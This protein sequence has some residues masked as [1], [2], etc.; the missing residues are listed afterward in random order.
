M[1]NKPNP[2]PMTTKW[3]KSI[4]KRLNQLETTLPATPATKTNNRSNS[5]SNHS[6][7]DDTFWALNELK[8]R[9]GNDGAILFAG[10]VTTPQGLQY[11][12]QH[13]QQA[14]E[15]LQADWSDRADALNAL[16]HP[17]RLQLLSHILSGV[18]TTAELTE[19]AE[20][21]TTGQLHHH[22]KPLLTTGWLRSKSRGNYE[23]PAARVVPL[24]VLLETASQ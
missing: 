6:N 21:A 24:L 8:K 7:N 10:S 18:T 3:Q 16:G 12:W 11:S 5:N 9:C 23:V 20:V 14:N 19:V 4:E 22:L 2:S 17:I 13:S 1:A 15:I